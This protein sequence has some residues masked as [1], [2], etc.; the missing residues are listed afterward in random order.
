MLGNFWKLGL[1]KTLGEMLCIILLAV[2]AEMCLPVHHTVTPQD[3]L[4]ADIWE[5]AACMGFPLCLL[6]SE[7]QNPLWEQCHNN[8]YF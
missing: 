3:I 7:I 5:I 2:D 4:S 8:K 1:L 6:R